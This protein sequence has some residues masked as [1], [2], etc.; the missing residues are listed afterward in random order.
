MTAPR[1]PASVELPAMPKSALRALQWAAGEAR[2]TARVRIEVWPTE[3]EVALVDSRALDVLTS[4]AE[5]VIHVHQPPQHEPP[6]PLPPNND[7]L[8]Y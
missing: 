7:R 3:H 8:D 1:T 2:Q 4:T 5:A 6:Q